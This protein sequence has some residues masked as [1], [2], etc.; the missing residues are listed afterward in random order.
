MIDPIQLEETILNIIA[1]IRV[2]DWVSFTMGQLRN[3]LQDVS[4]TLATSSDSEIADC[5]C[6]LEARSL[7]AARKINGG[8]AAPFERTRSSEDHYRHPFFLIGPFELKTT[9]EARKLVAQRGTVQK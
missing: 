1:G 8:S 5:V 2:D 3:R 4:V 6:S 9:H 7:I